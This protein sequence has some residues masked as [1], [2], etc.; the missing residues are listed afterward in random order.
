M[1][2]SKTCSTGIDRLHDQRPVTATGDAGNEQKWFDRHFREKAQYWRQ[3]YQEERDVFALIHQ[4]RME[5]VKKLAELLQLP[6]GTRILD[7]GCGPGLTAIAMAQRGYQVDALDSVPAMIDLTSQAAE[8]VG[9][10]PKVI[11]TVGD[12]HQLVYPDNSFQ[13]VIAMGVTPFLRSLGMAM[14][15]FVRVLKP[16]GHLIVNADNCWRLNQLLDP[17]VSPPLRSLRCRVKKAFLRRRDSVASNF[18]PHMYSPREFDAIIACAGLQV[19]SS[20][21]LGFGPFSFFG[22]RLPNRLGLP[23]HSALQA[24]ADL[25]FPVLRSTGSQYMV[26]ATKPH[27]GVRAA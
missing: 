19:V 10:A 5:R 2:E 22:L 18:S 6:A 26:L 25:Q 8:E 21:M 4:Q 24:L 12:C 9:V 17:L 1:L 16:G 23:L 27:E 7:V 15:E 20:S 13:A 11:A 3:I 14:S